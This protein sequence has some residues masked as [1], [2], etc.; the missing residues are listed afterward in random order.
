MCS[1]HRPARALS[2]PVLSS[3][4]W[5]RTGR[6]P[7]AT[8]DRD[9]SRT[10]LLVR[11]AAVAIHSCEGTSAKCAFCSDTPERGLRGRETSAPEAAVAQRVGADGAEEV[12]AP[13]IGPI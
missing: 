9:L 13:E 10:C 2:A 3:S 6:G 1:P 7:S 8:P 11:S 4:A 12:H 5:T